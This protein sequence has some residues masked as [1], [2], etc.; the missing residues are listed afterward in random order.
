MILISFI[1]IAG[2]Q[3]PSSKKFQLLGNIFENELRLQANPVGAE[4]V[5][6]EIMLAGQ[7]DLNQNEKL[8]K[9]YDINRGKQTL[10]V[11]ISSLKNGEYELYLLQV[12]YDD[13]L[14]RNVTRPVFSENFIKK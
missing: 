8:F 2:A 4:K 3:E 1:S 5:F 12:K 11:D 6:V 14:K 7:K 13:R 10:K 9:V